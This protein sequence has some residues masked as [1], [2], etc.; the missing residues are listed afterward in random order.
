MRLF[1]PTGQML[2]RPDAMTKHLISVR[3][4]SLIGCDLSTVHGVVFALFCFSAPQAQY[5]SA[6]H[7]LKQLLD[8][9]DRRLRLD[10]VAEI[11]DEPPLRKIRQR[12]VDRAVE[13]GAAC[14]QHQRIEIALSPSLGLHALADE[15]RLRGPVDADSVDAG[16]LDEPGELRTGTA[17]K[18]DDLR[19]RHLGAHALDDA[20]GRL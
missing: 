6:P 1:C 17:R 16:R 19:I 2:A 7:A 10:A 8:M 13:R 18:A 15:G 14:D 5:K 11:E 9:G 3:P 12:V 20:P 4:K